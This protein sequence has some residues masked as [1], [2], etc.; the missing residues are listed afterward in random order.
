MSIHH[1][2]ILQRYGLGRSFSLPAA[3]NHDPIFTTVFTSMFASL[4]LSTGAAA[5]AGSIASALTVTS[6]TAGVQY[7]DRD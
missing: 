3:V 6:F 4:G 1:Q 2:L 7:L 5:T